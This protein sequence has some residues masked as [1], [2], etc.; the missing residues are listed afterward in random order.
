MSQERQTWRWLQALFMFGLCTLQA[1]SQR[2]A[3]CSDGMTSGY[4]NITALNMDIADE[5]A[6]IE[7][8]GMPQPP[9]LYPLC[10][11]TV[12]D[13][14]SGPLLPLLSELTVTCGPSGDGMGC[15]LSGGTRQVL[16]ADSALDGYEVETVMFQGLTFMNFSET[17]IAAYA[18]ANTTATFMSCAWTVSFPGRP[19]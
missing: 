16:F 1:A 15:R 5:F 11:D 19:L 3:P 12:F 4:T 17:S 8:G 2:I 6:R 7:A 10:P 13:M 9:Y 18:S 14:S